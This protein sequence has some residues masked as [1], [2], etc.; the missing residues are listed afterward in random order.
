MLDN[1]Q[2]RLACG[3]DKW[4]SYMVPRAA[5]K[6]KRNFAPDAFLATIGAGRRILSFPS[7]SPGAR[8]LRHVRIVLIGA[9]HPI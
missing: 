2:S 7:P 4:E 5:T 6:K 3:I 1:R 8:A 9:Q